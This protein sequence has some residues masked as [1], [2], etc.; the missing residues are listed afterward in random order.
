[1]RLDPQPG[2]VRGNGLGIFPLR[3]LHI[4]VVEAKDEAPA[5]LQREQPV[6]QRRARIADMDVA[7][8]RGR[9]A[10][11]NT[12]VGGLADGSGIGKTRKQPA[13]GVAHK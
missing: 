9:E 7:R 1:M 2:E 4:G 5:M 11:G 12:H 6:E 13:R 10:D 3:A 8:R